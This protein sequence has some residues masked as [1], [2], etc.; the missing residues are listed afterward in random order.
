MAFVRDPS[1]LHQGSQSD[2]KG[3]VV[4][5]GGVSEGGSGALSVGPCGQRSKDLQHGLRGWNLV[6]HANFLLE[7]R[8]RPVPGSDRVSLSRIAG[9]PA[10]GVNALAYS[11]DAW[12][13]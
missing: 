2:E 8:E 1:N 13:R 6:R 12:T 7:N 11:K 3:V 5:V 10:L 4:Q 9:S